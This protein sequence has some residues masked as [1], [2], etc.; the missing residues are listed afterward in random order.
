MLNQLTK[1]LT[2]FQMLEHGESVVVGVSGGPDSL[3]LLHAL[4][5]LRELWSLRLVAVHVHHGLRGVDADADAAFVRMFCLDREIPFYL[6]ELDVQKLSLESGLSF[7]MEGRRIRYEAFEKVAAEENCQKIAI[8]QNMNDQCE[9]LLMRL[10][11][12]SGLKG[13]GATQ[14]VRDGR[15]IRPLI[16]TAREDIERYCE[17]NELNPRRDHTNFEPDYDRNRIRLEVIPYLEKNFNPR[18]VQTLARTADLLRDEE[19]LL[20]RVTAEALE[21][22]R[23]TGKETLHGP[24]PSDINGTIVPGSF[25]EGGVGISLKG[26]SAN[27]PALQKRMVRKM[28]EEVLGGVLT[29]LTLSHVDAILALTQSGAGTKRF[30]AVGLDVLR[31]YETLWVK[32]MILVPEKDTTA[33]HKVETD[34]QAPWVELE[35]QWQINLAEIDRKTWQLMP[36][37]DLNT[38]IAVDLDKICGTLRLRSREEGDRF[39]PLGMSASKRLKKFMI[40]EKIPQTQRG[41]IPLICD[42]KQIIWVYGYR[43]SEAVCIEEKTAR[44]GWLTLSHFGCPEPQNMLE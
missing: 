14:P 22:C 8:A 44:I 41:K 19:S 24:V 18:L 42:E 35:S 2:R 27:E 9:T 40:D 21:S 25:E 26:F 29:D 7:E 37:G 33:K 10:F 34:H 28:A 16:E 13:L 20:E 17:L 36:R 12:G 31:I 39:W 1:T 30:S 11:R 5:S 3:A 43:M 32:R 6:F 23:L 4:Y 15:F 38:G